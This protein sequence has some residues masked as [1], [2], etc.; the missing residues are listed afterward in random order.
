MAKTKKIKPPVI[1][2][3]KN[4]SIPKPVKGGKRPN[5][6]RKKGGKNKAT[7]EKKIVLKK[8]TQTIMR[9]WGGLIN[10]QFILANG[11]MKVFRIDTEI[12]SKGNKK[13]LRPVL[14]TDEEEIT[15]AIDWEFGEGENPNT[16]TEYYFVASTPPDNNAIRDLLDRAFGKATQT[17]ALDE[18]SEPLTKLTIKFVH[19]KNGTANRS[20]DSAGADAGASEAG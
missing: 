2:K 4:K 5:S 16:D 11:Y 3:L 10:S 8:L 20:N 9:R 15:D 13:K 19:P 14:V 6:G 18:E 7:L 1:D 12:D 17:L